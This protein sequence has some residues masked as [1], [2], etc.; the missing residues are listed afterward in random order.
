MPL[1]QLGGTITVTGVS[2]RIEVVRDHLGIPHVRA[3]SAPDAFFGQG[4]VHALDRLW[5]MEYD[6]RRAS[7]RLAEL[8]GPRMLTLDVF[9]RRL[10]IDGSA[11]RDHG[12]LDDET[13]TMLDAYTAGVNA[14]LD[15]GAPPPREFELLGIDAPPWE[16]WHCGAVLKIRHVLMGYYDMKLW[17]ERLVRALGPGA[18]IAPGSTDGREDLLIVPV[19][20]TETFRA[21]DGSLHEAVGTAVIPEGSNSWAV[22]GSR[23]ASGAPLIAGDPHRTL[24]CPN[25]YYQN[26]IACPEF[27][28]VGFS[29]VGVPG[30]FHFGHNAHTAWCVTHG[31]ADTQD[32]YVERFRDD[33]RYVFE[34]ELR[35]PMRRSETIRVRGEYDVEI[36]AITT[37][38]AP[39]LFGDP[40]TGTAISMRWT[41]IDRANRSLRCVLTMLRATSIDE[42]DELMRDWVDP[43]NNLVMADTGGH[44]GYLYRGRTPIRSRANAWVPVA[45][46]TGEHEWDGDIPFEELPRLRD[47][48]AGVIVTANNRVIGS[49]YPHFLGMDYSQPGRARRVLDRLLEL[50]NATADDMASVHSDVVSLPARSI[51]PEVMRVA[52]PPIADALDGWDGSMDAGGVAPTVYAVVRDQ[53]ASVLLEREPLRAVAD[54]PFVEDPYPTPAQAR[55]RTAMPRLLG[56]EVLTGDE[57]DDA[58]RQA[59]SRA[60]A[61]L[62]EQ[63]G[64]DRSSWTWQRLHV[65]RTLHPLSRVFADA[66]DELNPPSV[67]M[68]GDGDCVQAGSAEVGLWI[69]H[70]SVAR[71]VFDLGDWDNSGWIVPLGSSGHPESPHYADQASDWAAVRLQPMLYSWER[72]EADAETRQV[73][74]PSR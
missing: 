66:A 46:W 31:M 45:G 61:Y 5:Q 51:V 37:H 54:D 49:D 30:M 19:G 8:L 34:A 26:H 3:T 67:S 21:D 71:Y 68:A 73:L 40:G 23:T 74:E 39:V 60:I 41:G 43:C 24:E 12:A 58:I 22:H 47:P 28:A 63:L 20:A 27:D 15:S 38:H 10:D 11:K 36:D 13:R 6:R 32:L 16:A 14:F 72:I 35:E 70:S 17:R 7:G 59:C 29:M 18:A 2:A 56:R 52:P 50:T 33:G 69:Q 57:W 42:L 25:V 48:D 53:L 44:I 55:L 64:P 9:A 4:F 65:T 1:P 62:E